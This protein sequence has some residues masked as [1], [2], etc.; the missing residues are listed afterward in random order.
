MYMTHILRL[1]ETPL[2]ASSSCQAHTLLN[3][4]SAHYYEKQIENELNVPK[5]ER[6]SPVAFTFYILVKY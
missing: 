3:T 1:R 6:S 4:Q 5:F 2:K